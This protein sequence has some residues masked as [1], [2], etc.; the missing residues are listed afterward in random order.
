VI[1]LIALFISLGGT[2][3][4]VRGVGRP[5]A[6]V[7]KKKKKKKVKLIPGPQGAQG[8]RGPQG[9]QGLQG[10]Q[11]LQGQQGAIGPAGPSTIIQA[12]IQH[13]TLDG[14][15]VTVAS[16]GPLAL[17][18]DCVGGTTSVTARLSIENHDTGTAGFALGSSSTPVENS[19]LAHN[20]VVVAGASFGPFNATNSA[21]VRLVD[22]AVQ[23]PNGR[24]AGQLVM[25]VGQAINGG[26]SYCGFAVTL[27]QGAPGS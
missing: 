17:G 20:D 5:P 12:G 21:N 10:I 4:A 11:G 13:P 24:I 9:L 16:A 8:L 14:G 3:Y 23:S 15:V 25:S 26:S 2:G 19:V 1:S 22:F 7:A 27:T 6:T 18:G